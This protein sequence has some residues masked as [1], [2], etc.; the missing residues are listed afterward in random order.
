VRHRAERLGA[1]LER[2]ALAAG[3]Q[4]LDADPRR[5]APTG[6]RPP[7][8]KLR[9]L[10]L[11]AARAMLLYDQPIASERSGTLDLTVMTRSARGI[12]EGK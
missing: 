9:S 12:G 5:A 11:V 6:E 7:I 4:I 1:S 10:G 2:E 3:H 8:R